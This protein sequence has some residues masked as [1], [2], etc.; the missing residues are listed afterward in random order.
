MT[1]QRGDDVQRRGRDAPAGERTDAWMRTV[2]SSAVRGS[3]FVPVDVGG[4]PLLLARVR[5]GRVV[6]FE[7][8]CPH[9][10][11]PLTQGE[12][13]GD[14]LVCPHHRYA[15]DARTGANVFPASDEALS[16]A[17]FPAEDRDGWVWVRLSR[18]SSV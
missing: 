1:Q 9:Q 17:V 3:A 4:R 13:L 18:V 8:T 14:C 7:P 16:L 12:V 15:Y 6:A 11:Q 5:G 2:P 10:G